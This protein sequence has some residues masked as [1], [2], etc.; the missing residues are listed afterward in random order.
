MGSRGAFVAELLRIKLSSA[1]R[2][3]HTEEGGKCACTFCR[4]SY[5]ILLSSSILTLEY[6]RVGVYTPA[7]GQNAH[8][9]LLDP[10]F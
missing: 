4:R 7:A 8:L 10:A 3:H 9:C 5:I 6:I 1:A 2:R